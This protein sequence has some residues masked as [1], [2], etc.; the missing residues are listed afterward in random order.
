MADSG[1]DNATT[2]PTD[3]QKHFLW[4]F[5]F[6]LASPEEKGTM[7]QEI[8]SFRRC[9]FLLLTAFRIGQPALLNSLAFIPSLTRSA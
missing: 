3:Q 2:P 7:R 5:L 6:A 4:L 9:R 1:G 8:C